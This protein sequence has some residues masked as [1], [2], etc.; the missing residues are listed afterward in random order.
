MS[1]PA[2]PATPKPKNDPP[3]KPNTP[4]TG[5]GGNGNN[6]G[7]SG[8]TFFTGLGK[9][10]GN[11]VSALRENWAVFLLLIIVIGFLGGNVGLLAKLAGSKDDWDTIKT[12]IGGSIAMCFIGAIFF[13]I[14][15]YLF[16]SQYNLG[17]LHV[18][19]LISIVVSSLSLA[20]GLSAM[21]VAAITR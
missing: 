1:D 3:A 10:G 2:T 9:S 11:F 21:S 18:P 5:T 15:L 12:Q 13:A 6:G 7:N 14:A 20:I 19:M 4:T 16:V 17:N 8:G